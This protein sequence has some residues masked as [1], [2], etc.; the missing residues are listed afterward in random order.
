VPSFPL[1][2]ARL[3]FWLILFLMGVAWGLSFSLAKIAAEGGGHPLG[4][5][6]WQAMLGALFLSAVTLGQ[7]R[8]VSFKGN[9]PQLYVICALLGTVV[10]GVIFYAAA[11]HVPAGVLSISVTLVPILTVFLAVILRVERLALS[12][13]AGVLCGMAAVILLVGPEESLPSAAA[14]PWVLLACLASACYA[15]ENLVIALRMPESANPFMVACGMHLVATVVLL[16][17]VLATD[18]FVTLA[19]PWDRV[20]WS[21]VGLSALNAFAYSLFIYLVH[22][23]G[24]VFASQVAYVVTLSG[25][26]WGMAI[27]GEAHS[28]WVWLSLVVMLA[29]LAMVTPRRK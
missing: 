16:P 22:R 8:V 17:L 27:F 28:A 9:L 4:I 24:P 29:G 18:S 23:A 1:S 15:V 21:I 6:L 26:I 7:G 10:P 14:V 13:V 12:R 5:T 2:T 11:R 25:V 3:W 19:W 20:A